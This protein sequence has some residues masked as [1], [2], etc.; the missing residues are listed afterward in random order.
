MN[1]KWKEVSEFLSAAYLAA[2]RSC[3]KKVII[4]ICYL[5]FALFWQTK[6]QMSWNQMSA[7]GPT[8]CPNV[9]RLSQCIHHLR[10][11]F[12]RLWRGS[13]SHWYRVIYIMPDNQIFASVLGFCWN[14]YYLVCKCQENYHQVVPLA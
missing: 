9:D 1:L 8:I 3:I 13:G 7:W 10:K 14:K 12:V 5:I 11:S 2:L 6:C 4:N